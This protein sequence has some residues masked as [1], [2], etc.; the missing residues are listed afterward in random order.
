MIP[1]QSEKIDLIMPDLIAAQRE[2]E[3]VEKNAT[4][5]YHKSRYADLE[6]VMRACV[7]QLNDHKIAVTQAIVPATEGAPIVF[8]TLKIRDKKQYE[9]PT[10]VLAH[11]R[12]QL[13][14]ESGQWIA[15]E[16]PLACAW[17]DAQALGGTIT[18]LRR[19]ALAALVGLA[20]AD[21]DGT[22][23][24][25]LAGRPVAR[26]NGAPLRSDESRVEDFEEPD[27]GPEPG[28]A[29]YFRQNPDA[30]RDFAREEIRQRF[31]PGPPP[32]SGQLPGR[33][34]AAQRQDMLPGDGPECPYP[35]FPRDTGGLWGWIKTHGLIEWFEALG[36]KHELPTKMNDWPDDLRKWACDMYN[37]E[38]VM[39]LAAQANGR[40]P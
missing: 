39:A 18:Y 35:K 23:A 38:R 31:A 10:Q 28:S 16:I 6:A 30:A 37:H 5:T 24:R 2:M 40:Q 15:S 22:A 19:Y 33:A 13:T 11:L 12:T 17:G 20:Q 3:A 9:V 29:A 1:L 8:S 25:G 21:D 7:P 32:T 14:H 4:N 26:S 27:S 34:P 36:K